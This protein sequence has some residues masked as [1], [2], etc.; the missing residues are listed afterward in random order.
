MGPS[1]VGPR[2]YAVCVSDDVTPKQ[3]AAELGVRPQTIRQWLRSQGWQSVPYTRWRLSE[4]QV[5]EVR[6]HFQ[7]S[8][9]G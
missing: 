3:L 2:L 5:N 6:H 8:A 4:E 1:Q 9:R 7:R